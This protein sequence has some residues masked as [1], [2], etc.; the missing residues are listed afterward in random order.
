MYRFDA[1]TYEPLRRE[2]Y[3]GEDVVRVGDRG[4][5]IL[6]ALLRDPCRIVTV[7]DLL[8]AGWGER[9]ISPN[10]VTVQLTALR[11]ALGKTKQGGAFI[12]TVSGRGYM[13][14]V[15]VE[16][17]RLAH[18]RPGTGAAYV[19]LDVRLPAAATSFI[20]RQAEA[21]AL[22][23][24][25]ATARLVTVTGMGGVGKTRLVQEHLRRVA[26]ASGERMHMVDLAPL[27]SAKRLVEA[28]AATLQHSDATEAALAIR[29]RHGA[30]LL[31]LDN[32]EHLASALGQLLSRL[33]TLCPGL[34]VLV[35]SRQML[36]TP[37]E[38]VLQLKPFAA[39]VAMEGNREALLAY[40]CIRLFLDRAA[41][42]VPGFSAADT[43]LTL[44]AGLCRRLDGI[45]LALEMLIPRLRSLSL[46]EIAERLTERF[47]R[48]ALT[49]SY[50][51]PR[52]RTLST[53]MQWSWDLLNGAEQEAL[54]RM[55]VFRRPASLAL[56]AR[57]GEPGSISDWGLANAV[58]GLVA[59]SL[60]SPERAGSVTF[61]AMLQTTRDFVLAEIDPDSLNRMR[62]RHAV[63]MAVQLEQARDTWH[64]TPGLDW[65]S[66]WG[67]TAD[68]L[69]AALDWAFSPDGDVGLAS[70]LLA[71]S[72]TLWWELPGIPIRS[73]R[74]YFD[75]AERSSPTLEPTHLA[76]FHIGRSWRAVHLGD[77]ENRPA[78]QQA[79]VSA[80]QANAPVVLGAALLRLGTTLLRAETLDEA[81][82]VLDEA[83][84]MLR[85]AVPGKWLAL[86]LARRADVAVRRG[87]LT[88]AF[89]IYE[90]AGELTRFLDYGYGR[91]SVMSNMTEVL[92]ELGDR[93]GALDRL[94][95][96]RTELPPGLRSPAVAT[97]AAH[98]VADGQSRA[99]L[100]AVGEV[101][102]WV[103]ATGMLGPLGYA[104][105][106][107]GLLL[108]EEG[109]FA[110]AAT[111]AGFARHVLPSGATRF[112]S[113]RYV[114]DSLD[115]SLRGSLSDLELSRHLRAG[116]AWT[117]DIAEKCMQFEC[118]LL[119]TSM[120]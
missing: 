27:G 21:A 104:A 2:L 1:L 81:A 8:R 79:V 10:N 102:A 92:F 38:H 118:K 42:L 98:L 62:R 49:R 53:M 7:D 114:F 16:R 69:R 82:S 40:D 51:P 56:L 100:D 74:E 78:A 36:N 70:R 105:E 96:L 6:L 58:G 5:D 30:T 89:A 44:V 107:L 72:V 83:E 54:R 23:A 18:H 88:E 120:T 115:R 116:T 41:T 111:L 46:Q 65:F 63:E 28:L 103:P 110:T 35:T 106:V 13:L 95:G 19:S 25:L 12:R 57:L 90:E 108:A 17:E 14:Q 80:R 22:A 29:L 75:Q 20:G 37:G 61:Y 26:A 48:F 97:L 43:D 64:T 68:D 93:Q 85:Q 34:R 113:R 87:A 39:P 55:A 52:Q 15:Q 59:N 11:R 50:A 47:S 91:T 9:A 66:A 32:A 101:L 77:T 60:A 3:R 112:G 31:V 119:V 4:L 99:A 24:A 109:R 71:A 76:W 94:M 67:S 117:P 73:M 45:P 84:T 33:L 86:T